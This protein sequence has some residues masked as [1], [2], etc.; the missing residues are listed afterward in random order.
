MTDSNG[1]EMVRIPKGGGNMTARQGA[2]GQEVEFLGETASAAIAEKA[3]AGIEA[4]FIMARR[5]PRDLAV[6]RERLLAA[7]ARPGFAEVA[8][9]HKPVGDGIEGPSIRMAE[10]AARCMGNIDTSAVTVYDDQYKRIIEV[11]A[12]DLEVNLTYP[13][14]ITVEKTVERRK[15][16]GGQ[17]VRYQR[18]NSYGDTVFIV[19]ATDDEILNKTAALVSKS[20][21]TVLLRLLPGDILEEAME[22]ARAVRR[23]IDAKD[24]VGARDR[25]T[26][27]FDRLGVRVD[28][29]AAFLGH[30][31]SSVT[32]E[33][34]ERLRGLYNAIRDGET[35]WQEAVEKAQADAGRAVAV[36]SPVGT[37]SAEVAQSAQPGDSQSKPGDS[38]S[39]SQ[40]PARSLSE[41]AQ[42]AKGA[43]GPRAGSAPPPAEG[44]SPTPPPAAEP[45]APPPAPP[46]PGAPVPDWAQEDDREPGQEG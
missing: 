20:L 11:S 18:V 34:L 5:F 33:E 32:A 3:R 46:P 30:A 10:E 31:V 45:P 23:E 39:R 6:V 7:C 14:T 21:R 25:M 28:Q 22:K 4:R 44:P 26:A 24:L 43:R 35:T 37:N 2:M 13:Q 42:R 12:T 29:I 8:I 15:I 27:A 17:V 16:R 19:D 36:A 40:P 9:Y 1:A 41:A 38:Q